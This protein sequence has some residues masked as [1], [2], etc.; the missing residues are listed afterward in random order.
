MKG[1]S[2]AAC[3]WRAVVLDVLLVV[4]VGGGE[5]WSVIYFTVHDL[6]HRMSICFRSPLLE[7][8]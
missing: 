5:I 7:T 6:Y 8:A 2:G 3:P 4:S 1:V